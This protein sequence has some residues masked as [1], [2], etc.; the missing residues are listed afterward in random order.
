MSSQTQQAF[1]VKGNL[2][3]STFYDSNDI[4][5]RL[6]G[7]RNYTYDQNDNIT[8]EIYIS[9][10]ENGVRSY[11]EKRFIYKYDLK[12]NW[13]ERIEYENNLPKEIHLRELNYYN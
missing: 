9:F 13:V 12:G 6:S 10:N 8:K 1:D 4:R 11:D 7:K 5:K 2:T 3:E